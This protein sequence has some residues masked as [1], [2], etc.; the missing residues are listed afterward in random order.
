MK[1]FVP[2]YHHWYM[3][4]AHYS[5]RCRYCFTLLGILVVVSFWY[6]ALYRPF[7]KSIN[8]YIHTNSSM[9]VQMQE[10]DKAKELSSVLS[11]SIKGLEGDL[12]AYQTGAIDPDGQIT[13][14]AQQ[15]ISANLY[16]ETCVTEPIVDYGWYQV[17]PITVSVRGSLSAIVQWLKAV[18][19]KTKLLSMPSL[20]LTMLDQ[21]IMRCSA[22]ISS[23]NIASIS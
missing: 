4:M 6:L 13:F 23:I 17:Q 22:T 18:A 15:A 20:S 10:Q 1:Y 11:R 5:S 7:N 12:C 2:Q 9:R 3:H 16:L 19:A 21:T 8:Y 14:I